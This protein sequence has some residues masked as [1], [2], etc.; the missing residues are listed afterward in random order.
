MTTPLSPTAR[1][2]LIER[3]TA[4]ADDELVLGNRLASWTGH[5]PLLE[6]D[7]AVANLAQ[8]EIGHA[9]AWLELR[10]ALDNSDPDQLAYFRGPDEYRSSWLVEHERG[11]WA[12]TMLRQYLFDSYEAE[13]LASL[14]ASTYTPL[15]E[16]GAKLVREELFHLRHSRLWVERLAH[17]TDE[18]RRRLQAAVDTAW[19]LL[20][21]L[22]APLPHDNL[23]ETEGVIA[24]QDQLAQAVLGATRAELSAHGLALPPAAPV[25]AGNPR[26]HRTPHLAPMLELMQSVARADPAAERW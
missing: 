15:A 25:P 11:D 16:T 7:I 8:D 6:E 23:L 22:L 5:A 14:R 19:P 4:Y 1:A 12:F 21:Q 2:A 9:V 26:I 18:S 24:D 13:L 20:P 3:L 17:G 10:Q